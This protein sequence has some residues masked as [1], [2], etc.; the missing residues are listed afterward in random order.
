VPTLAMNRLI[1]SSIGSSWPPL[2]ALRRTPQ[3]L[4]SVRKPTH[5]FTVIQLVFGHRI[6]QGVPIRRDVHAKRR[7]QR[8]RRPPAFWPNLRV[9]R[10]DQ[11]LRPSPVN[12][13]NHLSRKL[14]APCDLFLHRVT[15]H[16]NGSPF[17][18]RR[19]LLKSMP[20][21]SKV[22]PE[23]ADFPDFPQGNLMTRRKQTPVSSAELRECGIRSFG[24]QRSAYTSGKRYDLP[25]IWH[26]MGRNT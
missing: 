16:A 15:T 21:S 17:R 3:T 5:G 12:H 11:R 24:D 14:R 19:G 7:R 8:H 18:P 13:R 20:K 22:P 4:P 23:T 1:S 9:V 2:G 6:T 26:A 25:K 10:L